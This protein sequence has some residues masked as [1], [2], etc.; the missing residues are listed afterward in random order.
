[1]RSL[2][3]AAAASCLLLGQTVCAQPGKKKPIPTPPETSQGMTVFFKSEESQG[4]LTVDWLSK[5]GKL[6]SMGTIAPLQELVLRE[7][8]EGHEFIISDPATETAQEVTARSDRSTYFVF[9]PGGDPVRVVCHLERAAFLNINVHPQWSPR[10]AV[11][12]LELVRRGHFT[13]NAITRVVPK[14]LAQFGISEDPE[15]RALISER[16]IPDDPPANRTGA[17]KFAEGM[18]SFAGSGADSRGSEMF[19]V[20]PGCSPEQLEAFGDNSWETPFGRVADVD[21]LRVVGGFKSYGD[22]PPWGSGPDHA[23]IHEEGYGFLKN[24][25]PDLDYFQGCRVVEKERPSQEL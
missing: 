18:L 23:R 21:S 5:D 2:L 7:V 8:G 24:S 15:V 11:R 14:F 6:V 22:M 10:G 20:M 3:L 4:T 19:F 12:F 9:T 16:T 1:M 25:Y 13:H 17:P